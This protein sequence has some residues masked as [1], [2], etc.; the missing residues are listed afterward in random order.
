MK[1]IRC[2]SYWKILFA[3]CFALAL[4]FLLGLA[5]TASAA[6]INVGCTVAE[7]VIAINTANSNA[8]ADTLALASNCTYAL[9]TVNNTSAE[10]GPNGLPV[11]TSDITV[12]GNGAAIA[13]DTSVAA[14]RLVQINPGAALTLND[15]TLAGGDPGAADDKNGYHGG[16][17]YSRGTCNLNHA[18]VENNHAGDGI[19]GDSYDYTTAGRGGD[20]GALYNEGTAALD[21][22]VLSSNRSGSASFTDIL[23]YGSTAGGNGGGIFNLGALTITNSEFK[24]NA[25][26]DT[27]GGVRGAGGQ[28]SGGAIYNV[29]ALTI[30]TTD[31]TANRTG[32]AQGYM[33]GESGGSGGAIYNNS[34]LNL[35]TSTFSGNTTGYNYGGTE[36]ESGGAVFNG[37]A[38]QLNLNSSDFANNHTGSGGSVY[39]G[40]RNGGA[41]GGVAN[42]GTAQIVDVTFDSNT[43][44]AG[45]GNIGFG[46]GGNGAGIYNSGILEL[47][48]STFSS[49]KTGDGGLGEY[50][51]GKGGSGGGMFNVGTATISNSTFYANLTGNGGKGPPMEGGGDGGGIANQG[52]LTLVNLT[53]SQNG[54][55]KRYESGRGG[56]IANSGGIVTLQNSIL[57]SSVSGNNCSGTLTDGGGNIRFPKTDSTCFGSYVDP[58]LGTLGD[59]GG[60]TQ[61]MSLAPDSQAINKGLDTNCPATD[62]RGITRPQGKHCDSGA[63]EL[64]PPTAI[65]L[66]APTD[67]DKKDNPL[68]N[69]K[70][71]PAQRTAWY[72]VVVKQDSTGGPKVAGG[73]T[74]ATQFRTPELKRGHW[75]Y[76]QVKACSKVSCAV[77]PW[78]RFRVK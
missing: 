27:P 72:R 15:L 77:S 38:G 70:W 9:T 76:W 2:I 73:K 23:H 74:G 69:L 48:D 58:K 71:N 50:G 28:G 4:G 7:L 66:V 46:Y 51:Q 36:D 20:G 3:L 44:G 55:G 43:T 62:E 16:A 67:G 25:T 54:V 53:L 32:N 5:P 8:D 29:G 49:N 13:R 41:G 21:E 1:T 63:F 11:I 12:N 24:E 37:A 14:F 40:G 22:A 78:W 31:F 68:V 52:T 30:S 10:F 18:T 47:S 57:A 33:S 60:T 39:G 35:T 6:N 19:P 45:G 61:T 34:V 26:A 56:G 17:I 59:N 65:T 64:E 75:Y 42:F